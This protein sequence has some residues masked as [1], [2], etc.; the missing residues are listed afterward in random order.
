MS[1]I[2]SPGL[3][4]VATNCNYHPGAKEGDYQFPGRGDAVDAKWHL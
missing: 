1:S 4:A 3:K 2:T